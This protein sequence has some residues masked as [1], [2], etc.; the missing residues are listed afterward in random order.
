[1]QS[2]QIQTKSKYQKPV[3]VQ[4]RQENAIKKI[5]EFLTSKLPP[6]ANQLFRIQ[7]KVVELQMQNANVNL[8]NDCLISLAETVNKLKD[9]LVSDANKCKK[10]LQNAEK[11]GGLLVI[12]EADLQIDKLIEKADE[13]ALLIGRPLHDTIQNFTNRLKQIQNPLGG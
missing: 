8:L 4:R 6:T 10:T 11:Q 1:M 9:E 13:Y 2:I 7:S 3:K 5:T 12:C